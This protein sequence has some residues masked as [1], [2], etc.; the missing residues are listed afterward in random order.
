[1][2]ID[3][4]LAD[5]VVNAEGKLYVQGGGWNMLFVRTLPANQP[6]LGIGILIRVPYTA[7]NHNHKFEVH[8]E[9][10]D[11]TLLPLGD[12]PP[13]SGLP[14]NKIRQFGGTFNVGRPPL[15]SPGDEQLVPIALN[16]DGLPFE[17]V[18]LFRFVI[19]IDGT[20]MKKLSFRVALL[21]EA[22]PVL[23]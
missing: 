5:S 19:Q 1:M 21:P 6:R 11:G 8:L 15:I 14:D 23:R 2:D 4:F 10:E 22:A 20:P 17:K 18:G 9:D 7:T 16:I 13:D 3:A 12:A